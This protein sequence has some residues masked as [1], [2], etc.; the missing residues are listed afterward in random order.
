MPEPIISRASI[1]EMADAAAAR[2]VA[3]LSLGKPQNP[4]DE[5][6]SPQARRQWQCDFER[7]LVKHS[8]PEAEGSA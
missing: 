2:W 3:D 5:F 7:A 1:A 4:Y 6:S 8:A